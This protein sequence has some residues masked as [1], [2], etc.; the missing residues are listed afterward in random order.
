MRD[1]PIVT[2]DG[3]DAKDLDDAVYVKQLGKDEFLLGVHIADV[4]YYVKER[5]FG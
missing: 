4:S 3:D 1:L 5:C 2:V